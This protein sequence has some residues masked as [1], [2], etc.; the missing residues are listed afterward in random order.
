MQVTGARKDTDG[1][2][3]IRDYPQLH[4]RWR[5]CSE[6]V[7]EVSH[8]SPDKPHGVRTAIANT[9]AD[10]RHPRQAPAPDFVNTKPALPGNDGLLRG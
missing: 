4:V 8:G 9:H 1:P 10:R 7:L 6:K 2:V 5:L 3:G